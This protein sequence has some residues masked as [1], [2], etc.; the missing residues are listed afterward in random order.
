MP[1]CL[2]ADIPVQCRHLGDYVTLKVHRYWVLSIFYKMYPYVMSLTRPRPCRI[3]RWG[4]IYTSLCDFIMQL[5]PSQVF[6]QSIPNFPASNLP[7]FQ[8]VQSI[9]NVEFSLSVSVF[10]VSFSYISLALTVNFNVNGTLKEIILL[11]GL[12]IF[13]NYR[14]PQNILG[15][16]LVLVSLSWVSHSSDFQIIHTSVL[17]SPN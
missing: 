2:G 4:Q 17:Y 3:I 8:L 6:Q 16:F 11:I 15:I 1:K 13:C 7:V 14:S 9:Q 12:C 5:F 10:S